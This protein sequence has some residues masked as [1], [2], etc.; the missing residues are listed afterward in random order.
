MHRPAFITVERAALGP[1]LEAGMARKTCDGCPHRATCVELCPDI[2][3]MLPDEN[4]GS[5]HKS[6]PLNGQFAPDPD[7]V[8]RLVVIMER[9][10]LTP[11]EWAV[12]VRLARGYDLSDICIIVNKTEAAVKQLFF[13]ARQKIEPHI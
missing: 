12:T 9:A 13:R 11:S 8:D 4:A 3:S 1:A 10:N 5:R 2:F 6:L 7:K